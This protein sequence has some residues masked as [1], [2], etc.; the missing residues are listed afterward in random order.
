MTVQVMC[1]GRTLI[2]TLLPPSCVMAA[3]DNM[4]VCTWLSCVLVCHQHFSF[5]LLRGMVSLC[6]VL[7]KSACFRSAFIPDLLYPNKSTHHPLMIT[8]HYQ[9]STGRSWSTLFSQIPLE[10]YRRVPPASPVQ[11]SSRRHIGRGNIKH[12]F[13]LAYLPTGKK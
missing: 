9:H 6:I 7:C 11:L 2:L 10:D 12:F 8:T 4:L 13:F 3:G 1:F 5:V